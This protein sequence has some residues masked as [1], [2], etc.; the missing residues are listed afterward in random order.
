MAYSA[1]GCAQTSRKWA[2]ASSAFAHA[3]ID[4]GRAVGGPNVRRVEQPGTRAA[5]A[6]RGS[7]R[8]GHY[9]RDRMVPQHRAQR[10]RRRWGGAG[11]AGSGGAGGRQNVHSGHH[12]G[13]RDSQTLPIGSYEYATP[14]TV[15]EQTSGSNRV[16]V[17]VL[18]YAAVAR[19]LG[20]RGRGGIEERGHRALRSR[21]YWGQRAQ[22]KRQDDEGGDQGGPNLCEMRP[23]WVGIAPS[24]AWVSAGRRQNCLKGQKSASRHD[25]AAGNERSGG[26]IYYHNPVL[27]RRLRLHRFR[28]LFSSGTVT[29]TISGNPFTLWKQFY[30][31]DILRALEESIHHTAVEG[32][33]EKADSHLC[34]AQNADHAG[35]AGSDPAVDPVVDPVYDRR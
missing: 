8:I 18:P 7:E 35:I 15:V 22:S 27:P 9:Q 13:R 28:G 12:R 33:Q 20:Q 14:R 3:R 26:R 2:G 16:I 31:E 21:G 25:G 5:C 6:V 32:T 19:M 10:L 30:R 11:A 24:V 4:C 17:S 23:V 29:V 34:S 1:G